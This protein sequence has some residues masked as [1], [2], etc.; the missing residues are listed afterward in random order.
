MPSKL[1]SEFNY[2]YLVNGETPWEKIKI[3]KGFLE[4][5]K[6]A[7]ALEEVAAKKRLAKELELEN[8]KNNNALPHV[9]LNL[10][11]ELLESKSF[12]EGQT[13]A[14]ELNRQEIAFLENYLAEI[15][16]IAEPTR[17]PGYSDEQM[18]EA[19]AAYEFTV[20]LGKEI[21]AEI[22]ANGRPSPAKLRNAMSNPYTFE[23]LKRVGLIPQE[24]VLLDT[25]VQNPLELAFNEVINETKKLQ[26]NNSNDIPAD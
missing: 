13:E 23:T 4:G 12:D 17:I 19:N 25:T 11:A 16:E 7:A 8:C 15:Y 6:R 9:I 2:R 3:L 14:W 5:R 24:A 10:E 1:N 18:F 21:Q 20:M 22:I 26:L